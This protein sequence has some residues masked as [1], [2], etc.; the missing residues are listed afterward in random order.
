MRAL[1]GT[2]GNTVMSLVVYMVHYS[3]VMSNDD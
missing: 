3:L 1:D 2:T